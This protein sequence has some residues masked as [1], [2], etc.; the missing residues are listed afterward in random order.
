MSVLDGSLD[1]RPV[2]LVREFHLAAGIPDRNS[3]PPRLEDVEHRKLESL[4]DSE[5]AELTASLGGTGGGG[6]R[7]VIEI[8]DALGDIF[9]VAVGATLQLGIGYTGSVESALIRRDI[10]ISHSDSRLVTMDQVAGVYWAGLSKSQ[11]HSMSMAVRSYRRRTDPILVDDVDRVMRDLQSAGSQFKSG[12]RTYELSTLS[13]SLGVA[14]VA[15]HLMAFRLGIHLGL[16]FDEIHRSNMTKI[17]AN[18]EVIRRPD[19]KILKG[20][21][22]EP[23]VLRPQTRDLP[24]DEN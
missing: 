21:G 4:L 3:F 2:S 24:S 13:S 23:P 20:P 15:C 9:Y 18:L 6:V 10:E 16:V 1:P 8:A 7:Q 14:I 11:P 19:G 12:L 22:F 17:P 5:L